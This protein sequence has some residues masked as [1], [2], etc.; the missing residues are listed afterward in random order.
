MHA[1]YHLPNLVHHPTPRPDLKPT[2][3]WAKASRQGAN[4]LSG[5]LSAALF[6]PGFLGAD[7][8]E[9]DTPPTQGADATLRF[10]DQDL[11]PPHHLHSMTW[12]ENTLHAMQ[13]PLESIRA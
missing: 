11:H 8:D 9:A 6:A 3:W 13:L 7:F 10:A 2:R 5:W 4:R 1:L 12:H